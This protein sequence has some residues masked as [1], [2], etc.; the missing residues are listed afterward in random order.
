MYLE[1]EVPPMYGYTPDCKYP[2]VYGERGIIVLTIS[3]PITDNSINQ[4]QHMSKNFERGAVPDD[5]HLT[6]INGETFHVIGQRSPSNAPEL[7]INAVTLLPI[8]VENKLVGELAD[9]FNWLKLLHDDHHGKSLGIDYSDKD[10]GKLSLTPTNIEFNHHSVELSISIRYPISVTEEDILTELEKHIP[11]SST[12][13]INKRMPSVVFDKH[14]KMIDD[15][16]DIYETVTQLDGTPVTTTGATYARTM[17]NIIA[18]GPSF[19]GQKGIAHNKD[20]YMTQN[21]LMMNLN[22]YGLLLAKLGS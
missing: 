1:K 13:S 3:T 8:Q 9:Y 5:I 21:D 18:F 2:A 15:M 12:I 22:I 11:V 19:P 10:S 14:H 16:T 7:G 6:L 4:I 17:P 20:E